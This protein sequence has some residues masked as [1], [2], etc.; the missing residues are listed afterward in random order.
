MACHDIEIA[1]FHF[2][3]TDRFSSRVT[4]LLFFSILFYSILF[5]SL[6][7]PPHHC[8]CESLRSTLSN[9]TNICHV[10]FS[11]LLFSSKLYL[12][13][14]LTRLYRGEEWLVSPTG[15]LLIAFC[16]CCHCICIYRSEF[17]PQ[18]AR[19]K[20][21]VLTAAGTMVWEAPGFCRYHLDLPHSPP[22]EITS[23]TQVA[24]VMGCSHNWSGNGQQQSNKNQANKK[25]QYW[26]QTYHTN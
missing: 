25:P 19:S 7:C 24:M 26:I 3:A 11:C 8:L 17:L 2:M 20:C 23:L 15:F 5:M 18:K 4:L 16:F 1:I 13:T 12:G 6:Y 9:M 10:F 14:C 21:C 22:I